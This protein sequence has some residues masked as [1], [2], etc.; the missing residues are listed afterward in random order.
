[1]PKNEYI[2]DCNMV[3]KEMVQ[4]TLSKMPENET[5]NNLADLFKIMGDTT[6]CKLL[7]ALLQNEMCVCDL[8]NVLSMSKS[9]ISHQL[10][11]MKDVGLVKCRKEGK[12]VYYS[13]DDCH[14]SEIFEVGLKHINHK[15]ER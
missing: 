13:L 7:F 1:M 12:T 15:N 3:H 14:I 11:K 6:R 9:S 8:A 10:S 5:L 4:D 2:C